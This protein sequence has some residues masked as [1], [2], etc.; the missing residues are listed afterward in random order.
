MEYFIIIW[1]PSVSKIVQKHRGTR[2]S[3]C[4][5]H[6]KTVSNSV[7]LSEGATVT[8]GGRAGPPAFVF[9]YMCL[10]LCICVCICVYVFVF[11]FVYMC[12]YLC[13]CVCIC[14][15]VFVFVF[16][17]MCLYLCI[18]VC[19]CECECV[20]AGGISAAYLHVTSSILS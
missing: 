11:V 19:C 15:Y 9:V 4:S 6:C 20:C 8:K 12:L 13:I 5:C 2:F 7:C 16:V 14:V 3:R 17:Y 10:Y 18:C 1:W